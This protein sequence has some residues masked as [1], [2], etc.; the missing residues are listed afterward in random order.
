LRAQESGAFSDARHSHYTHAMKTGVKMSL[1]GVALIVLLLVYPF[2][3]TVAPEWNVKVVD[4]NGKPV[5]GAYVSEFASHGTLDFQ[6]NESVCTN[7]NGDAQ[8][9]RHT[10][11]ASVLTRVSSWVS[12]F[13]IHGGLGG[14]VAVGV[15]RVGYG[16]MPTQTQAPDFNG[17][18]WSGSSNLISSRVVLHKCPDGF[19]GYKCQAD[20][21]YFFAVNSSARDIAACQSA[22]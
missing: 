1:A 4:E 16:D 18:V 13:S 19:T 17:L 7:M 6:H 21:K 10:I 20:Y 22:P 3:V 12:R 14:H 15:D 2:N 11:R 9:V 5:P 8:F